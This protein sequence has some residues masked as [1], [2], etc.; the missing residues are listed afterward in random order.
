VCTMLESVSVSKLLYFM[1]A[2][3][4]YIFNIYTVHNWAWGG[5]AVKAL[6]Y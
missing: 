6:R 2:A 5:I 3:A 4:L 1:A